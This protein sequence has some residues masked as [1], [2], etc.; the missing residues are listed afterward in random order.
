MTGIQRYDASWRGK[1]RQY[2]SRLNGRLWIDVQ[3]DQ[4]VTELTVFSITPDELVSP[5]SE[6]LITETIQEWLTMIERK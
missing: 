4:R 5:G 6:Q 3:T 1:L 2:E